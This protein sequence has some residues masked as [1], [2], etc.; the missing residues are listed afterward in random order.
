[1]TKEFDPYHKWLGIAPEERLPTYYRLLGLNL[2]ESDLEVI[3][4]AADRQMSY[5]QDISQAA[6]AEQ[7]QK[8]LDEIAEARIC[9]LNAEKKAAYDKRL[10]EQLAALDAGQRLRSPGQPSQSQ[11]AVAKESRRKTQPS[12]KTRSAAPTPTKKKATSQKLA[13][14]NKEKP[15]AISPAK[16]SPVASESRDHRLFFL[17]AIVAV[18]VVFGVGVWFFSGGESTPESSLTAREESGSV[19]SE[20]QQADRSAAQRPGLEIPPIGGAVG[21]ADAV[22]VPPTPKPSVNE[23][24][25]FDEPVVEDSENVSAEREA[26]Q[27]ETDE[28]EDSVAEPVEEETPAE[29]PKDIAKQPLEFVEL[30]VQKKDQKTKFRYGKQ[31]DYYVVVE[32]STAKPYRLK[33]KAPRGPF[34]G[35]CLEMHGPTNKSATLA[36]VDVSSTKKVTWSSAADSVGQGSAAALVDDETEWKTYFNSD[37]P[38]WAVFAA[39]KPFGKPGAHSLKIVLDHSDQSQ[40][41]PR[42][43]LW[44]ITGSGTAEEMAQAMRDRE[45]AKNPFADFVAHGLPAGGTGEVGLGSVFLG[46]EKLAAQLFGGNTDPGGVRFSLEPDDTE[47]ENDSAEDSQ[48]WQFV[49]SSG[50][51]QTPV[52]ELIQKADKLTLGWLPAAAQFNVSAALQNGLLQLRIGQYIRNVPLREV[53]DL[54]ALSYDPLKTVKPQIEVPAGVSAEDL[55]LVL[56]LPQKTFQVDERLVLEVAGEQEERVIPLRDGVILKLDASWE[57]PNVILNIKTL[58][59]VTVEDKKGKKRTRDMPLRRAFGEISKLDQQIKKFTALSEL[60]KRVEKYADRSR[61]KPQE[62]REMMLITKQWRAMGFPRTVTAEQ[63]EKMVGIVE[64]KKSEIASRRDR[65]K[66]LQAWAGQV[67]SAGEIEF[68]IYTLIDGVPLDLVRSTGWQE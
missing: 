34:I 52:A 64:A 7:A 43:R 59:R 12:K 24:G 18:I 5:L 4:A 49:L 54:V 26:A 15:A 68:R 9:L 41:L 35:L 19:G 25:T 2:F 67:G 33:I 50:S 22:P 10:R 55:R 66:D 56:H 27:K 1:M 39:E 47:A 30:E 44:G 20:S 6:E 46:K 14:A 45:R 36:G 3:D 16:E 38:I 8:L 13:K 65:L 53:T 57:P 21:S 32:E 11:P 17:V 48:R 58:L 63:A 61:L 37:E 60:I 23:A 29:T 62:K 28:Q 51:E 42:F 40:R 31:G